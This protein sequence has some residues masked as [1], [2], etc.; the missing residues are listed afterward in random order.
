MWILER[1]GRWCG[2]SVER[3]GCELTSC[4][5]RVVGRGDSVDM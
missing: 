2:G 5:R 1:V 4:E 3:K